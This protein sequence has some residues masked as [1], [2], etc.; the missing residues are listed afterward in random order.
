[1][2]ELLKKYDAIVIGSGASGAVMAYELSKKG[3]KVLVVERGKRFEPSQDFQHNELKMYSRLYK[4][5]GLQTTKN[6]DITI[7][8]GQTVG[9]STVI[10]NAI[11]L[12]ANLDKILPKWKSLGADVPKLKLEEAYTEIERKLKVKKIQPHEANAGS[13]KFI[14]ACK[15][16]NIPADYL[17][18][19]REQ[20]LGCGWCNYGCKYDRKTSMLVTYLPWSENNGAT[21]Q[22]EVQSVVVTYKNN[23][24]N[25]ISFLLH[26]KPH[27][28]AADKII[29]CAG[30]IGS[31]EVMLKSGLDVNGNVGKKFHALG[32]CFVNALMT[33]KINAFDG[34]GLSCIAHASNEYL[35]ETFHSPPGI[36][37]ITI[38]AWYEDHHELM[39]NYPYM[40]QAGVMV[41][42]D[43][44]G[45]IKLDKKKR[46]VIDF[47]FSEKNLTS[48][49]RGIQTLAGIYFKAGAIQVMP[50]SFKKII[51]SGHSQM[52]KIDEQIKKL[53]DI[54]I[55]SAHPQ[56]GNIMND[57][58]NHGVVNSQFAV[59]G[60]KNL[61]I[62]DTSVWPSNIWANCQA[63]TMA[64]S[65]YAS[66]FII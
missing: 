4:H 62:A 8:Q 60:M 1:M 50:S 46:V 5:S 23:I 53:N 66:E 58:K 51:I 11:W 65:K 20:C 7:A 43:P 35:I 48:L 28:I 3:L 6:N 42:S 55:G 2:A 45:K 64:M 34:I 36:F 12:R 29:L 30:A 14:N 54:T 15:E 13:V 63:T 56:G 32:G 24:A 25:G 61:F 18:H 38:G 31:S 59:H 16:L 47:K 33:E 44:S 19:N 22:D 37:S 17:T 9:G 57:D 10:N 39:L 41:A 21:I 26:N 40:M 52:N 49:K 27:L